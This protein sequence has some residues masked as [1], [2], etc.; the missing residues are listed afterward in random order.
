[1]KITKVELMPVTV[2]YR[3]PIVHAFGGRKPATT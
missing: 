2:P 3:F 1:M